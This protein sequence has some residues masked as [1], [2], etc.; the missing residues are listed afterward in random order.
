M[1]METRA[2]L[3]ITTA[4]TD[5]IFDELMSRS[6]TQRMRET[7]NQLL[8]RVPTIE[9]LL[10]DFMKGQADR[11]IKRAMLYMQ[12]KEDLQ[13]VPPQQFIECVLAGAEMGF[14]LDGKMCYVVKYKD[15]YQCQLSYIALVAVAKRMKTIKG[16]DCDVI[17]SND[18][19]SH[20]RSE[21]TS[22]L[23]HSYDL[24]V[25]R[26]RIIGAYCRIFLP[27]GTWVYEIMDRSE[28]D[29]I[30]SIA[31]SKKGPWLNHANEMRKKTV[32]R[33]GLKLHMDDPG[34]IRIME[35]TEEPLDE[36][37]DEK[38]QFTPP[39]GIDELTQ[40]IERRPPPVDVETQKEARN[41]DEEKTAETKEPDH[42]A[43]DG[44]PE[45]LKPSSPAKTSSR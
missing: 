2:V 43:L 4:K 7:N 34:L 22:K 5:E 36:P 18:R 27:D 17:S 6:V 13:D 26:S 35:L 39:R 45:A 32:L 16:A 29:R 33:R 11:L 9:E 15:K 21:G 20:E 25:D 38:P 8:K 3:G 10:P 41:S 37:A 24:G 14:A 1:S 31:P 23:S 40:R 44:L 19:F 12:S 42:T 30:Q 28:L